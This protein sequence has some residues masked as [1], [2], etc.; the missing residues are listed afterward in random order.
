MTARNLARELVLWL[1]VGLVPI[2]NGAIR[3]ALY[4]RWVGEPRASMVSSALDVLAVCAYAS[5]VQRR[6]PTATWGGA[7]GRGLT[8]LGL[9]TLNHF[10]LG[11]LVFGVPLHAL[12]AKYDLLAGEPW[13]L[14]SVAILAAPILGRWI[15]ARVPAQAPTLGP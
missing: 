2:L 3:L 13:L 9:T 1:P 15:A 8:W 14:V 7:V 4:A 11:A 12:V 5:L 10:A 6:W